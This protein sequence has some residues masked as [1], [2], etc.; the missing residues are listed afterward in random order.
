MT[1]P[2][3]H[4]I[5]T[6]K[7]AIR[8]GFGRAVLTRQG[9]DRGN[10]TFGRQPIAELIQI[11]DKA[12]LFGAVGPD[13]LLQPGF[14]AG[15][16]HRAFVK[17]QHFAERIIS[18]H[19]HNAL[20]PGK[21]AFDPTVEPRCDHPAVQG[22]H[23]FLERITGITGQERA[24]DQHRMGG[25]RRVLLIGFQHQINHRATIAPATGCHQNVRGI[26]HFRMVD[27]L[28]PQIAGPIHAIARC[29]GDGK[30]RG[31]IIDRVHPIHPNFVVKGLGRGHRPLAVP[32][33]GKH[34]GLVQHI[35]QA[36]NDAGLAAAVEHL[37]RGQQ[38]TAKAGGFFVHDQKI[39]LV[40][41]HGRLDQA[42]AQRRGG[43]DIRAIRL[44]DV[45][46]VG[47]FLDPGQ[48]DVI[49][50]F[51]KGETARHGTAGQNNGRGRSTRLGQRRGQRT[52]ASQMT[53]AK[54]VVAIKKYATLVRADLRRRCWSRMGHSRRLYL[55]AL[56]S[57]ARLR[58]E[59]LNR[60]ISQQ[61]IFPSHAVSRTVT[62]GGCASELVRLIG[63]DVEDGA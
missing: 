16:D 48:T 22:S 5:Q 38:F 36:Q 40:L 52:A 32:F 13:P 17:G 60:R 63:T 56:W 3:N 44:A 19:R 4:H 58:S 47:Q 43:V 10:H 30:A 11:A 54:C 8:P 27:H 28:T 2:L 24:I 20:C 6:V 33:G 29:I 46:P 49:H 31:G 62:R 21:K 45:R 41:I 7:Q 26:R 42:G 50:R 55:V 1:R 57:L 51:G 37:K 12:Q 61:S 25:Q 59:N 35:T 34:F 14:G 15:H 18:T 39:R 53:Q 9:A 23:A